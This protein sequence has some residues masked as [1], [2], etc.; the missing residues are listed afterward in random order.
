MTL[1]IVIKNQMIHDQTTKEYVERRTAEG[2][3]YRVI[4]RFLTWYL[5]RSNFRQFEKIFTLASGVNGQ[6]NRYS[7]I[8]PRSNSTHRPST[9][10]PTQVYRR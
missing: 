6:D 2:L 1:D 8:F 9:W 5:A 4:K 10:S 7:H 3:S